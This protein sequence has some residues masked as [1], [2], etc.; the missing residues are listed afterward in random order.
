[1]KYPVKLKTYFFILFTEK[2]H[3]NADTL[4]SYENYN[5]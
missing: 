3:K 1:M 2:R 5:F 4:S